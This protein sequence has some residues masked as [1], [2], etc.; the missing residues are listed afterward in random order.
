MENSIR[1][2]NL[3]SQLEQMLLN[4]TVMTEA[5]MELKEKCITGEKYVCYLRS[6]AV[7]AARVMTTMQNSSKSYLLLAHKLLISIIKIIN[8]TPSSD[9]CSLKME[10]EK[11]LAILEREMMDIEDCDSA[12]AS[13]TGDL[14]NVNA[15]T[16]TDKIRYLEVKQKISESSFLPATSSARSLRSDT[17]EKYPESWSKESLIDLNNVMNLAPVPEDIFMDF[18]KPVRSSSLSSLKSLRKVRLHLQKATHSEEDTQSD[19][20]EHDMIHVS[21]PLS[22]YRILGTFYDY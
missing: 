2:V 11:L 16:I 5:G 17:D 13:I 6:L 21:N 10:C 14:Y 22:K 15:Q 7:R 8:T 18:S 9:K 19:C 4:V 1:M 12:E 20:E 3:R